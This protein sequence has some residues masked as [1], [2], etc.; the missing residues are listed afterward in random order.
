MITY[1]EIE[2]FHEEFREELAYVE[3]D[4]VIGA[5]EYASERDTYRAILIGTNESWLQGLKLSTG[6]NLTERDIREHKATAVVSDLFVKYA[7]NGKDPVG[8]KIQ[9]KV[10][11]SSIMELYVVG[12][13][14]YDKTKFGSEEKG[15]SDKSRITPIITPI[16]FAMDQSDKDLN[17]FN[18]FMFGAADGVDPTKLAAKTEK[19]F[20]ENILKDKE[21]IRLSCVSLASQL[22]MISSMLDIVT[23][24]ISVIAAISLIVG[25]VGVMNIMLVSVVERTKEIGIRKAMGAQNSYI[26][27]QFLT[28]AV[29]ICLIGGILGISIG[30][31]NG[32]I[33]GKVG[34]AILA[35]MMPSTSALLTISIVPSATAIIISLVFSMLTGMIF[36][37]YPA[38]RAARLSPIDALRYE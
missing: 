26:H 3:V 29:V 30:I 9:L 2:R 7:M 19:Y 34:A 38:K 37:S 14:E 36:G 23:V 16:T 24:A 25:G 33:I 21:N 17:R 8:K 31:L 28:E 18:Y 35:N 13:Y 11:D 1:E 32:V 22:K 12:V 6:R 4:N 5:V 15:K 27:M 20:Q 10:V